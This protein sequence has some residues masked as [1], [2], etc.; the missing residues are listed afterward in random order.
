MLTP[1]GRR[2]IS[3]S[4]RKRMQDPKRREHLSK[5]YKGKPSKGGHVTN[6]TKLGNFNSACPWCIQELNE[7]Y[8]RAQEL[9]R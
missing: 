4:V 7:G 1:D 6:H 8:Q 3:E 2:R 5:L 9:N